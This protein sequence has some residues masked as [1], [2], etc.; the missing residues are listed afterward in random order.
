MFQTLYLGQLRWTSQQSYEPEFLDGLTLEETCPKA[1]IVG[2]RVDV[3]SDLLPKH[4]TLK[5]MVSRAYSKSLIQAYTAP[6][7]PATFYW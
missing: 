7:P 2:S 3:K 6:L 5:Q 1:E 4:F